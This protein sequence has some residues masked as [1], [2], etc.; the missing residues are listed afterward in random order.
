M[1]DDVNNKVPSLKRTSRT[2]ETREAT[3]QRKPWAPP[4]R[5]DAPP[6][7]PGYKHR[8]IRM[9]IAGAEDKMNVTAKL[10]EGYELVR[11][12]EYP[13][14]HSSHIDDGDYAGVISSGGMMLAR[15]PEETAEE[16]QAY[17]S[18]RTQDQI[19]AADNDLLKSNAHS[20]M[21]INSPERNSRVSIGGPRNGNAD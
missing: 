16:R 15:I 18:S 8:W 19:S 20:S 13:E 5:L 14:F 1:S 17:Y 6:A 10:R 7:P 21:K 12:D 11:A 9:N 3:A 2:T 4:S